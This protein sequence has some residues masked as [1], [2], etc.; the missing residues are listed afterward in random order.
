MYSLHH[1]S[2]IQRALIT[3][4]KYIDKSLNKL[5]DKKS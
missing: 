1:G 2:R 5:M 4:E 3:N